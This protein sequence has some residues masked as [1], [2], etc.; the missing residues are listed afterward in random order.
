LLHLK[1]RTNTV[2][3]KD[4]EVAAVW[5]VCLFHSKH[6]IPLTILYL[7]SSVCWMEQGGEKVHDADLA[8]QM[9]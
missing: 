2:N 6:G 9:Q 4:I 5:A 3:K 7:Y 1:Q 8:L